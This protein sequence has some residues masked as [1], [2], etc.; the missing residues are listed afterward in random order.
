[1]ELNLRLAALNPSFVSITYGAGGATRERT[2]DTVSRIHKE[3]KLEAAAHLTCVSATSEEVDSVARQYWDTGI[4]H[5]VA[6]RGDSPKGV[7]DYVSDTKRY[8]SAEDLVAGLKKIADFQISVAAYPESHPKASSPEADLDNL[9][10]KIDAGATQAITQYFFNVD[11]YLTI[12]RTNARAAGIT[13]PIIPGILP[14]IN[15]KRVVRI[16][17]T[18]WG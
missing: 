4:H 13:V 14:I 1:M 12:F 3:T 15:F 16:F 8:L 2:H 18:L 10:R 17:K 7:Y 9:K 6:L 11:T 5:I